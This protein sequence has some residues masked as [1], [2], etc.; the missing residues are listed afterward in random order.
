M[1]HFRFRRTLARAFAALL[2]ALLAAGAALASSHR[3][4]PGISKD[5]VADNTD[6]V[7]LPRPGRSL[8]ARP[9]RQLDPAR[10]AGGRPELLALRREHPL[11][12]QRRLERRRPRG[13]RLPRRVHAPRAQRGHVP[14]EHGTRRRSPT[15]PNQNVYYTYTVKKCVGPLAEPD[16]LP[17]A[18]RGPARGAEQPRPEVVSERLP[19][20]IARTRSTTTPSS[21]PA[22]APS[23]FYVDLGMIFDLVNFRPGTLPGNHGGGTNSTRR[24]QRPLDRPLR[25]RSGS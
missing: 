22:R 7:L 6:I 10:G 19:T 18:R 13:H 23:G 17:A 24:L 3:E 12:V 11:R 8:P 4:A 5:P 20:S 2:P 1:S 14:A 15:D 25:A 9:D 16:V 21:S